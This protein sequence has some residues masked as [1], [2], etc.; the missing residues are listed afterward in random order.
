MMSMTRWWQLAVGAAFGAA[1]MVYFP[2][3]I[4]AASIVIGGLLAWASLRS[5]GDDLLTAMAAGFLTG[6]LGWELAHLTIQ[7]TWT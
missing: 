4:I 2:A 3:Q 1:A 7:L 5:D 6:V